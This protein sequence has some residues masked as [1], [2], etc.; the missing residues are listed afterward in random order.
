MEQVITTSIQQERIKVKQIL[1]FVLQCLLF[2]VITGSQIQ[3]FGSYYFCFGVYFALLWCHFNPFFLSISYLVGCGLRSLTMIGLYVHTTT[4]LFGMIL[5]ILLLRDKKTINRYIWIALSGLSQVMLLYQHSTDLISAVV[6]CAG[7]LL[8]MVVTYIAICCFSGTIIRGYTK[9]LNLDEQICLYILGLIF[10]MGLPTSIYGVNLFLW[11]STFCILSL[12]YLKKSQF[13]IL[14]SVLFGLGGYFSSFYSGYVVGYVLIGLMILAFKNTNRY[15]TTVAVLMTHL[16]TSYVLHGYEITIATLVGLLL[17]AVMFI[18][19]PKKYFEKWLYQFF[20]IDSQ[21][22][23]RNIVNRS[24]DSL[25]KRISTISMVFKEMDRAYRH[26]VQ[27]LISEEE[28]KM[29]MTNELRSMMCKNCAERHHC[30]KNTMLV[31]A[32]K[33]MVAT[34][35]EKGKV[36]LLDIPQYLSSNCKR[37]NA[38]LATTN[39]LLAS[40]KHYASMITNMDSSRLLIADTLSGMSEVLNKLSLEVQS[41]ISYD[42]AKEERIIADLSYDNIYVTEAVVYEQNIYVKNVTLIVKNFHKTIQETKQ[43][44]K[45]VGKVC[46]TKMK[47]VSMELGTQPSTHII[48]LKTSPN[49]D[50]VYGTAT[51]TKSGVVS[52]GDT[53]SLIEIDTG[54]YMVALCDGMGSGEKAHSGSQLAIGLLENFYKAGFDNEMILTSINKLLSLSNDEHFNALDVTVLDFQ[55]N[56]MDFIKL[57]APKGYLK[58]SEETIVIGTNGLPLGVLEEMKPHITQKKVENFDMII[59]VTDGISDAFGSSDALKNYIHTLDTINPQTMADSILQQA[60]TLEDGKPQDDM[61]VSVVRVFKV[62]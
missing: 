9:K 4:I 26:M 59:M 46:G 36:S 45:I 57:G 8:G 2:Y 42:G 16:F 41:N 47:I 22:A 14:I 50:L 48:Q 20:P 25:C 62:V 11:I 37:L 17:I 18:S 12:S 39:Q 35:F 51:C 7:V 6:C 43:I 23:V 29:M 24:K 60:M 21:M 34:G 56:T 54:K 33:E 58:R 61:S 31:D 5:S 38:M 27:G 28:A 55:N 13:L 49:Y 32:M 15:I 1:S 44:E 19:I 10:A 52:S 30:H 40:Y 53:H 3:G